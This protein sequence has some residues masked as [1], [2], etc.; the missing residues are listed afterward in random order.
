M[1]QGQLNKAMRTLL[2]VSPP[3]VVSENL[4]TCTVNQ[5]TNTSRAFST[6]NRVPTTEVMIRKRSSQYQKTVLQVS[7][8]SHMDCS[9]LFI[10]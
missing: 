6:R 4:S 1:F 10:V 7:D 5:R 9:V 2:L 3:E 8:H